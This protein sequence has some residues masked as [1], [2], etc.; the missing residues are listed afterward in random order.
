MGSTGLT[1]AA[2]LGGPVLSS[3]FAPEGQELSSFEGQGAI[4]PRAMLS[5]AN[6]LINRIGRGI[7]D[8]AATPVS[9]PS[10]Y[11][12]QP[13][14][15]TGGGLPM[16]IGLVA[17]DPALANPS[18]LSLQ[19]LGQFQNI[20]NDIQTNGS[21]TGPGGDEEPPITPDPTGPPDGVPAAFAPQ[22]ASARSGPRRR[23]EGAGLV[24][25]S[26]LIAADAGQADDLEQGMGAVEL[27]LQAMNGSGGATQR[28]G[29]LL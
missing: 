19:G 12:Q 14:S 24:R 16:P 25:A 7:T 17:S 9:L 22:S 20:F 10:A 2:L 29:A 23:S 26:D 18:L 11:A 8:R 6:T 1:A 3:L 15:Y 27:L 5:N 4:D 28:T 13:G 21:Y